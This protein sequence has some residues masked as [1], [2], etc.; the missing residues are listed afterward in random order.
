MK[1]TC[2]CGAVLELNLAGMNGPRWQHPPLMTTDCR[3]G[4]PAFTTCSDADAVAAFRVFAE[5]RR[6]DLFS[7]I[8]PEGS[9]PVPVELLARIVG[10]LDAPG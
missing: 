6:E 10:L 3:L 1:P 8:L 2:E 9:I 7:P 4:S 5:L